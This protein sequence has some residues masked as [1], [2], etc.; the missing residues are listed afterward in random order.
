MS[1][2]RYRHDCDQCVFLGQ[3][4]NRDDLY[5]CG[6]QRLGWTVLAR[7][8]DEPSDY[9]SGMSGSFSMPELIEARR[10]A[11]ALGLIAYPLDQALHF[12]HAQSPKDLVL[13]FE[14]Q[15]QG[16]LLVRFCEALKQNTAD[17]EQ[18]L[19]LLQRLSE[20]A[21]FD[22]DRLWG[23]VRKCLEIQG[24]TGKQLFE[25]MSRLVACQEEADIPD[26]P[27]L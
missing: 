12:I 23:W 16:H 1:Y 19:E 3:Y 8:G 15:T 24:L 22:E 5:A 11:Q 4:M 20:E 9:N 25:V 14:A 27:I 13:E 10:R 17:L 21:P 7:H 18:Y 6:Q 26:N 2:R